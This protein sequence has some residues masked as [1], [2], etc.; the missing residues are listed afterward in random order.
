MRFAQGPDSGEQ[1][2]CGTEQSGK[3]DQHSVINDPPYHIDCASVCT[4]S[5]K[6]AGLR[7]YKSWAP[8]TRVSILNRSAKPEANFQTFRNPRIR[9][10]RSCRL[11]E[12]LCGFKN[13]LRLYCI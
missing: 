8:G 4:Y 3:P 7:K 9:S 12:I 2:D 10:L 6:P 11:Y 13:A 1:S 5:T